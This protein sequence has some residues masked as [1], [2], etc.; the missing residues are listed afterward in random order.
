[1][2]KFFIFVICIIC[3]V[4]IILKPQLVSNGVIN[5]LNLSYSAII[6]SLFPFL[7]LTNYMI[8]KDICSYLSMIIYPLLSKLFRISK[9]GAFCIIIGFTCGYPLGIKTINDMYELRKISESEAKYLCTFCN[10]CSL[11]FL[12]NYIA[13]KCLGTTLLQAGINKY[14]IFILVYMPSIIV[15][16]INSFIFKPATDN[17]YLQPLNDNRD[18]ISD[19][20]KSIIKLCTYVIVFSVLLEFIKKISMTFLSK[21]III[22]FLE[23][24]NGAFFT[25]NN[26]DNISIKIFIVLI[27]C[28]FGGVSITMQSISMLNNKMFIKYYLFGKLQCVGIFIVLYLIIYNIFI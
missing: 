25:A 23:I 19:S 5:G 8:S 27:F 22:S 24:T 4:A 18:V 26:I 3:V 21:S 17:T 9:Q 13:Y 2:K 11:S 15:G 6:P 1:M 16:I 28:I 20:V 7:L 14:I 12:M 10:N